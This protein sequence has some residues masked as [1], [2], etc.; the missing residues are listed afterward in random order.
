MTQYFSIYHKLDKKVKPLIL[1]KLSF[2]ISLN[3]SEIIFR[4]MAD[5]DKFTNQR[6]ISG[7]TFARIKP[8]LRSGL[9]HRF[10]LTF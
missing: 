6:K 1:S 5:F 3:I 9:I 10:Y 2:E 7:L 8:L 4:R